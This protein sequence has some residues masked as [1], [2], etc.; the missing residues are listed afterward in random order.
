MLSL[1]QVSQDQVAED[2]ILDFI[3]VRPIIL[4]SLLD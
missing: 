3:A 4:Q 1:S 2:I